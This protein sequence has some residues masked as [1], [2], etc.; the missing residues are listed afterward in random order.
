MGW[1]TG[2]AAAIYAGAQSAGGVSRCTM[3]DDSWTDRVADRA[4]VQDRA[5]GPFAGWL[6]LWLP[7]A[8]DA[9][10]HDP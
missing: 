5:S 10:F 8:R 3:D 6:Y 7:A 4:A 2:G 9:Q 1:L